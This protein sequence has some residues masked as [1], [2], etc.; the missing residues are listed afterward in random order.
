MN[1]DPLARNPESFVSALGPD[2]IKREL[3]RNMI[4]QMGRD[5]SFATKQDWFTRSPIS[6]A[7]G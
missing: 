3:A 6:C 1:T 4:Q 5:P 7:D 2:E